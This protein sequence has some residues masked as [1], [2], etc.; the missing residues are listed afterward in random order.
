[1]AMFSCEMLSILRAEGGVIRFCDL[2]SRHVREFKM[3]KESA[4]I[5]RANAF[6]ETVCGEF[7]RHIKRSEKFQQISG[8][9]GESRELR[10]VE[11]RS[12][13][14]FGRSLGVQG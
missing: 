9:S 4:Q 12:L 10:D 11:L 2:L 13:W 14:Y 7:R 5:V 6:P 3:F 1:M 8:R